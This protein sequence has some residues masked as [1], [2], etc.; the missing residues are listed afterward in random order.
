MSSMGVLYPNMYII[1][2]GPPGSGKT[3]AVSQTQRLWARANKF[4]IAPDSITGAGL[5]DHLKANGLKTFSRNGHFISYY[6]CLVPSEEFGNLIKTHDK[7]FL[8]LLNK[9]YDNPDVVSERTRKAGEVL[10]IDNPTM[11]ILAGTQ[12]AYIDDIFPELAWRQG[13]TSRLIMIYCADQPKRKV[14]GEKYIE[15]SR[16][17]QLAAHVARLAELQGEF[18]WSDEAADELETWHESGL[19]PAPRHFRLVT[20]NSR[21]LAHVIKLCMVHSAAE[22]DSLVIQVHHLEA[23]RMALLEA[24]SAMPEIFKEVSGRSAAAAMEQALHWAIEEHLRTKKPVSEFNLTWQLS[25]KV[26][27]YEVTKIIEN[28]VNAGMLKEHGVHA[29]V[30]QRMFLPIE[31]NQFGEIE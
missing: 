12:P 2:V 31:L 20:Y 29:P 30:G 15:A 14:F 5:M 24:E 11:T 26:P 23:A 19:D 1:L 21:R 8:S 22:D 7:D 4:N 16:N 6:S 17:P 27:A 28:M 3:V 25:R 10:P 13:F 9:I 18:T